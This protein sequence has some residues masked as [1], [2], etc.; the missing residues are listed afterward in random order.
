MYGSKKYYMPREV[1]AKPCQA[2]DA[3]YEKHDTLVPQGY[4]PESQGYLVENAFGKRYWVP[5]LMFEQD[6]RPTD[7]WKNRLEREYYEVGKR[8]NALNQFVYQTSEDPWGET[9]KKIGA[10]QTTLLRA[11]LFAMKSYQTILAQRL[12][13][14]G[15]F[16][17]DEEPDEY[18]D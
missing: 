15:V 11:Q 16:D 4:A 9:A 1:E 18:N 10:E 7:D 14:A 12:Y 13:A 3:R 8:I 2:K 17:E 5:Q 6:Y